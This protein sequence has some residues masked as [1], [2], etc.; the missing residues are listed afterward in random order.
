MSTYNFDKKKQI[1]K[2]D[3]KIASD[4][5]YGCFEH[6]DYGEDL[7]GGLW[8]NDEDELVDFDGMHILPVEVA[9]AIID[10]G[11]KVEVESF[12]NV[13]EEFN[14][15]TKCGSELKPTESGYFALEGTCDKCAKGEA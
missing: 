1:G 12:C 14:K 8:F 10:L 3:V 2:F 9:R 6:D 7:G 4:S 15:C 5:N 13:V 11:Y